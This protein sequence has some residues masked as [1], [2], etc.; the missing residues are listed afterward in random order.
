MSRTTLITL[1]CV[2]AVLTAGLRVGGLV[3]HGIVLGGLAGIG[4]TTFGVAYQRQLLARRPQFAVG[5]LGL[6]LVAKLFV[7]LG[8]GLAIRFWEPAAARVDLRSTLLTFAGVAVVVLLVGTVENARWMKRLDPHSKA[9]RA[10]QAGDP[11]SVRGQ[12]GPAA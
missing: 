7:L 10:P 1:V 12:T 4:V 9:A 11:S 3:G 2:A 6:F 5:V 8:L